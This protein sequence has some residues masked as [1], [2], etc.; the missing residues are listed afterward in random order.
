MT[1]NLHTTQFNLT[2]FNFGTMTHKNDASPQSSEPKTSKPDSNSPKSPANEP[3][4][5]ETVWRELVKKINSLLGK[6]TTS[7]PSSRINSAALAPP[8]IHH[9]K[10]NPSTAVFIQ[11][12]QASSTDNINTS[13]LSKVPHFKSIHLNRMVLALMVS[14]WIAT[15]FYGV[16][17]GHVAVITQF[18]EPIETRMPGLGWHL[19][20]P[21]QADTVI[22]VAGV[23]Q[24]NIGSQ[25]K[26]TNTNASTNISTNKQNK[27]NLML[28]ADESLLNIQFEV[29]YRLKDKAVLAY[30]FTYMT[31]KVSS[32]ATINRRADNLIALL[33]DSAMREEISRHTIDSIFSKDRTSITQA[34]QA[35]LQ[36]QLDRYTVKKTDDINAPYL[37][38]GIYISNVSIQTVRPP[39]PL[40]AAFDEVVQAAQNKDRV[41]SDNQAVANESLLRAKVKASQVILEAKNYKQ[42]IVKI[43]EGDVARFKP[44]QAEYV[45]Y[46]ELTRQRLYLDT[47]QSVLQSTNKIMIDT[48]NN[49]TFHLPLDKLS[50][51]K[52]SLDKPSVSTAM[53]PPNVLPTK[54][55]L[56]SSDMSKSLSSASDSSQANRDRDAK[57]FR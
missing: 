50:L 6:K 13:I 9:S 55:T 42:S 57:E 48:K 19:P 40:Q 49:N 7:K 26:S 34:V 43:A 14:I 25:L 16:P 36:Q 47:M 4:D 30:A 52:L 54:D 8:K 1:M 22:D 53:S 28:T 20:Y 35:R 10:Q 27:H 33:A 3:P 18:G 45:K 15:G 31:P 38:T 37:G 23:R 21:I 56:V 29:Q 51:D 17:E 12:A 46:P 32:Y 44:I 11:S 41:I 2:Q 5:L 39:E 24:I